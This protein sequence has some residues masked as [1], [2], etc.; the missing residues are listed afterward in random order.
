MGITSAPI[1][2]TELN[3]YLK[4]SSE[5]IVSRHSLQ[6]LVHSPTLYTKQQENDSIISHSFHSLEKNKKAHKTTYSQVGGL[7]QLKWLMKP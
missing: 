7:N 6:S 5:V 4:I 3:G 2:L 1:E